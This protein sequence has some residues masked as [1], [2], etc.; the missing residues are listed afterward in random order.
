ML[1]AGEFEVP[2]P[3]QGVSEWPLVGDPLYDLWSLAHVNLQEALAKVAPQLRALGTWLLA[4]GAGTGLAIVQFVISII[5]AGVLL[6]NAAGGGGAARAVS[7]RLA[8][9]RGEEFADLAG[10]TVQ[11]VSVGI[12]GVALIQ[13]TLIGIGL[14]VAG[15]PH[16]ALW[17]VICVFLT[18]LQLPAFLVVIP[19]IVYMFSYATTTAAVLFTI[20]GTLAGLSDNVLKPILLARGVDLPMI[21]IFMGAIGGF[22]SAGFVGLFVGAVVLALGYELFVAWLDEGSET[23]A[24]AGESPA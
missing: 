4:A 18:V 15:V 17:T 11:S 13:S 8:G 9:D 5:I 6:A 21:V 12:V 19:A 16:A 7:R 23:A 1:N 10:A 2:A 24:D 14:F 20:W 3:P 22:L